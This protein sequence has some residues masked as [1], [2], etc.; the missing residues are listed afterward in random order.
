M[1]FGRYVPAFCGYLGVFIVTG[2]VKE[3]K[4]QYV[5]TWNI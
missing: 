2:T 1:D 3:P 4:Y 5:K